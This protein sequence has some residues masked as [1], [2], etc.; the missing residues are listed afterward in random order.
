MVGLDGI[1]VTHSPRDVKFTLYNS[2]EVDEVFQYLKVLRTN[3]PAARK[4]S[5][6]FRSNF[7]SSQVSETYSTMVQIYT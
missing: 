3:P 4:L 6:Y 7:L 1:R 5:K 2:I